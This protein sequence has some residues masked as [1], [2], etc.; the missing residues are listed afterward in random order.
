MLSRL[1]IMPSALVMVQKYK[2]SRGNN[3]KIPFGTVAHY[4]HTEP[5]GLYHP[6]FNEFQHAMKNTEPFDADVATYDAISDIFGLFSQIYPEKKDRV[7]A[8]NGHLGALL[9][10]Q[11]TVVEADGVKSDGV[12]DQPC[13]DSKAYLV[14]MEVKNEIGTDHSDPYNQGSLA[15]QKYWAS[16]R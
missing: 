3:Q 16:R 4:N 11:F 13:G 12:V 7:K 9:G 1:P 14:I 6:V 15:Y 2:R 5:I 8:I 10:R